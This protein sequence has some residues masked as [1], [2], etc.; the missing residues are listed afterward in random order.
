MLIYRVMRNDGSKLAYRTVMRQLDRTEG[1]L[2]ELRKS[3]LGPSTALGHGVV[4]KDAVA[5]IIQIAIDR[6]VGKRIR[7]MTKWWKE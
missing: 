3:M 5:R 7:L 6:A 4:W 2:R 1:T